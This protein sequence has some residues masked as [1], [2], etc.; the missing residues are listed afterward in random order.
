MSRGARACEWEGAAQRARD[1]TGAWEGVITWGQELYRG[2][3]YGVCR[4]MGRCKSLGE[5]ASERGHRPGRIQEHG[6]A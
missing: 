2:H 4:H 1:G 6:G 3:V 5:Q